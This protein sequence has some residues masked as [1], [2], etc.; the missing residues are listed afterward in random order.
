MGGNMMDCEICG[1]SK[2]RDIEMYPMQLGLPVIRDAVKGTVWVQDCR[3]CK[4]CAFVIAE[5]LQKEIPQGKK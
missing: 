5:L 3:V 2:D 4:E 1:K